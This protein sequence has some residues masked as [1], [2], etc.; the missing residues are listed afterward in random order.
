MEF[1]PNR[2][3]VPAG[4]RLVVV[5]TNTDPVMAHD[6]VLN[7][8][9][10]PRVAPGATA[11]LDAGI[12]G[13]DTQGWC[14]VAGHRQMGMVLDVVDLMEHPTHFD[15]FIIASGDAELTARVLAFQDDLRDQAHAKGATVRRHNRS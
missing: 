1:T 14:S 11:E 10:T 4:D 7:G 15:E 12:I 2:I 8:A 9:R 3:E 13:A 6:L 5:L